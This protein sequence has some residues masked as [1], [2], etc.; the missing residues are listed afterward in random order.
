[1]GAIRIQVENRPPLDIDEVGLEGWQRSVI[2]G[3]IGF[4]RIDAR[5]VKLT[6][7]RSI[8]PSNICGQLPASDAVSRAIEPFRPLPP[9]LRQVSL[10]LRGDLLR[11]ALA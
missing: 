1:A 8:N 7:D 4:D 6:F 5:G 9:L 10:K 2:D 11:V 3:W